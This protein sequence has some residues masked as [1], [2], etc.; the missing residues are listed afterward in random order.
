MNAV[1]C[2]SLLKALQWRVTMNIKITVLE[3]LLCFWPY[4]IH[5]YLF[6]LD[7][8]LR[9]KS[10]LIP[11]QASSL[12]WHRNGC[13]RVCGVISSPKGRHSLSLQKCSSQFKLLLLSV[14][15]WFWQVCNLGE[16]VDA[17]LPIEVAVSEERSSGTREAHHR[18]RNR[19][20]HI[21]LGALLD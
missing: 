7:Q 10:I 12:N 2:H 15:V 5:I 17:L 21:H 9:D 3:R 19:D 18:Q 1:P 4:V 8:N 16:E 20:R 13:L 11:R 14:F 6:F